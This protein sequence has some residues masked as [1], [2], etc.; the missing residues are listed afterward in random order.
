MQVGFNER[1]T[2]PVG[3]N[4]CGETFAW[5]KACGNAY[6]M[7]HMNCT[8]AMHPSP[9]KR[10]RSLRSLAVLFV[11]CS[12]WMGCG[13]DAPPTPYYG[14]SD[15]LFTSTAAER[16]AA[17]E[18]LESMQRDLL[19][20]AFDRLSGYRFQRYLR[21]EQYRPSGTARGALERV[22]RYQ[23]RGDTLQA[24]LVRN[25]SLGTL[26][27]AGGLARLAPTTAPTALPADLLAEILPDDPAYVAPRTQEGY[28]YRLRA[29]TLASGAPVDVV[30]AR[31]QPDERGHD[32]TVRHAQMYLH[33]DTRQ[34][35]AVHLVRAER[36]ALFSEDSEFFLSLRAAPDTGWVPHLTRFHTRVSVPFR[37]PSEV[38]TVSA[39][40]AYSPAN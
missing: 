39:F 2:R 18:A 10:A 8:S 6:A 33:S 22:I 36:A 4:F 26:S 12:L 9:A 21:T 37:S 13:S 19:R 27:E 7:K 40:Y 17:L 23:P 38:R 20:G 15:A 16:A 32:L 3:R 30:E 1:A 28:R 14:T 24:T 29:D 35:L 34:L 5:V 25:D 11:L 31:A